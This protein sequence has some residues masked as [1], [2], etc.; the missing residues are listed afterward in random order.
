LDDVQ[1]CSTCGGRG[2]E[3]V[4][5]RS[6]FGQFVSVTTCRTCGGG[7]TVIRNPCPTC[8]GEG[9]IR[10]QKKIEVEVPP[11]VTSENYITLR[12]R[13]NVGPRGGPRGD[14][15]VLL[16]VES[17]ERFQREGRHL[18]VDAVVTFAQAA[19]GAE[20]EIPTV[21]GP[22]TLTIPAGIQSG[23]AVRLKGRGFP[24]LN[25]SR[26]G[27]LVARIRVWTPT[28]LSE[29]QKKLFAQVGELEAPPPKKVDEAGVGSGGFWSKV[30]EAF[31]ST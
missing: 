11:G 27:D 12:G 10:D 17:D 23:H 26:R 31:T 8:H 9:R 5:Q 4:A 13:G 29:E 14:I 21:E 24:E 16:E 22:E 25:G 7:G 20:I 28:E 2:E 30:K 1:T 19:L 18:V 6:V 15:V 3:H